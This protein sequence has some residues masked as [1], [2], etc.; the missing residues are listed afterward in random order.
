M[1]DRHRELFDWGHSH[2]A[3]A[4]VLSK[5]FGISLSRNASIGRAYRMNYPPRAERG[6]GTSRGGRKNAA[7][8]FKKAAPLKPRKVKEPEP[9][10]ENITLLELTDHT[11]RW[12]VE[13]TGADCRFCGHMP[14]PGSSYCAHHWERSV[15]QA[16]PSA[17][18]KFTRYA[19]WLSKQVITAGA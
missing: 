9:M 6:K 2:S 1:Q 3:I 19:G 12:P 8:K 14:V 10:A 18:N 7:P 4:R 16:T 15:V 17:R 13:G 5:E 11:C